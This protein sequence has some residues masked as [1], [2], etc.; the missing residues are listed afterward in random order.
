[1]VGRAHRPRVSRRPDRSSLLRRSRL[2]GC[3]FASGTTDGAQISDRE[4]DNRRSAW[5]ALY[6]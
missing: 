6:F 4:A 5:E 2:F 1:M 3:D